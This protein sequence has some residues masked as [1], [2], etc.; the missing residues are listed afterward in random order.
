MRTLTEKDY[1]KAA[2]TMG[3]EV[4]L[5]KAVAE[6]E[7][8]GTGFFENGEPKILFEAHWFSRFTKG[9]YDEEYPEISSPKWNRK[10]YVGGKKEYNRLGIAISLN[11][12]AA[13]KSTSWGKFQ[14]MGFNHKLCGYEDVQIFVDAMYE[15]EFNHL[16]AF[17][18]YCESR[19]LI[20]Y[21]LNHNWEEFARRYNGL[22]YKENRYDEKLKEAFEKWKF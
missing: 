15:S 2:E 6:V 13:L 4:A 5:I 16:M 7:S 9:I 14:I 1:I 18:R 22:G 20:Q 21:L 19:N 8:R 17:I 11:K 10:L 12:E 3:C